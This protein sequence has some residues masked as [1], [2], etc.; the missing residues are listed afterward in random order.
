MVALPIS[1]TMCR[2]PIMEFIQ[3][4]NHK[5]SSYNDLSVASPVTMTNRQESER[6]DRPDSRTRTPPRPPPTMRRAHAQLCG[7][8]LLEGGIFFWVTTRF[9]DSLRQNGG[10]YTTSID[11]NVKEIT[12]IYL[13]VVS[14]AA[15]IVAAVPDQASTIKF[16][17]LNSHKR[18]NW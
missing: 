15:A 13:S 10:S 5:G 3:P 7:K 18:G 9:W 2:G 12:M 11:F 14:L 8:P 16:K 1:E 17:V 6:M 4:Q